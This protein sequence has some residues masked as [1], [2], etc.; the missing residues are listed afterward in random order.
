MT[1]SVQ[2]PRKYPCPGCT[3][4]KCGR[5]LLADIT[6]SVEHL[7][8]Q[9]HEEWAVVFEDAKALFAELTRRTVELETWA[10]NLSK[11][12][13]EAEKLMEVSRDANRP[14]PSQE[15]PA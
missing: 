8:R 2:G 4:P 1:D 3:C 11:W 14:A 5:I 6:D 15:T 7:L 12:S 10:Q 13:H 9:G